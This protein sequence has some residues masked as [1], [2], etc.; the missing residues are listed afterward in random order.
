L[1]RSEVPTQV[2]PKGRTLCLL[3]S[4]V[5]KSMPGEN[6]NRARPHR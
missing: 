1:M 5:T 6:K 4:D 3:S 2:P